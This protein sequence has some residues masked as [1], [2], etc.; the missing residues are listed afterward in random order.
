MTRYHLTSCSVTKAVCMIMIGLFAAN[1]VA[2]KDATTAQTTIMAS[3]TESIT[4]AS[5]TEG[6]ITAHFVKEKAMK[7][8]LLQML[9]NNMQ[10]AKSIW[11]D[12]VEPNS[13][14]EQCGFFKARSAGHSNEDGVRTNADFSMICAFLYRYGKG[15]VRLPEGIT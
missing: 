4:M 5:P 6:T 2:A 8:D 14:G 13:A 11:Y 7:R 10:Y 1:N 15:K 3:P 9:A 12:C